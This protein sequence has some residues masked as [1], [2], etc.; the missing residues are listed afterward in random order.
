MIKLLY[1]ENDFELKQY[2]KTIISDFGNKNATEKIDG[3]S[4]TA[5]DLPDLLSGMSLFSANRLVIIYEASANREVWEKLSDYIKDDRS[6]TRLILVETKPDRRAKTFKDLQKYAEVKEFKNLT[7]SDVR[8][9]LM[10]EAKKHNIKIT[11]VLAEKI[12]FRT[13]A[14]QWKLFFA[15]KKLA[16]VETVDETAIEE[17]IEASTTANVFALID[18]S[19]QR[20]SEKIHKLVSE[21][22]TNEDPY[23]FFGL[24]SSQM[25]QLITLAVSDKKP[26]EVAADLGVHPY[27]LQKLSSIARELKKSD[28]RK[29]AAIVAECD[30]RL[31]RSGAEP[32]LL[33][34]QAL[35]KLANR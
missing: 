11:P 27:P 33:I 3:D 14:D 18:A 23:F 15:L 35:S 8:D 17:Q 16:E 24:F 4:I 5:N 25:F 26:S 34:E 19:L 12:I 29:I 21:L 9:W 32:W 28:I 30:D 2:L 22:S 1:G 6:S 13:G 10:V 7:E 31:K 20:S